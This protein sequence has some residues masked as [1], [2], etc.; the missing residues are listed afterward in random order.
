MHLVLRFL[1]SHHTFV[2]MRLQFLVVVFSVEDVISP[3]HVVLIHRFQF[4]R[5][6]ALLNA[7]LHSSFI[8][9]VPLHEFFIY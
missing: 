1:K 3:F 8:I 4:Y 2:N 5:F 7:E 9:R 6:K